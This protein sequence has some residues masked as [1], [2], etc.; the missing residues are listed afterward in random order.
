MKTA[1]SALTAFSACAAARWYLD[2]SSRAGA[3]LAEEVS[4]R[5]GIPVVCHAA[6]ERLADQ[7]ADL[8]LFPI[9][10]RMKR[11]WE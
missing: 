5:T 6:E 8:P 10:I 11:P 7:L 4:R 2:R 9:E 1:F 3:D